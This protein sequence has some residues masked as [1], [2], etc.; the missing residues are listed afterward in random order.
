ME[1]TKK[2]T[3]T[4]DHIL[5][6]FNLSAADHQVVI[7]M[8]CTHR[9]KGKLYSSA[10]HLFIFNKCLAFHDHGNAQKSFLVTFDNI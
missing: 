9:R 3:T 7:E 2:G 4:Q 1:E 6:L 10:G 5:R 8:E